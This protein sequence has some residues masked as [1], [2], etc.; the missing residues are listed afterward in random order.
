M[1]IGIDL[2]DVLSKTTAAFI[3]FHN[4][5]YGTTLDIKNKEKYG[6]WEIID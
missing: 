6:W 5:N 3:E 4:K 1:K 2:D